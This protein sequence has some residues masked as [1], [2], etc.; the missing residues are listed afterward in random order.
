MPLACTLKM[1]KVVNVCYAYFT[2]IKIALVVFKVKKNNVPLS[3]GWEGM[4][5][6][7][8]PQLLVSTWAA[9]L[10]KGKSWDWVWHP[11]PGPPTQG[12]HMEFV[13]LSEAPVDHLLRQVLP[14]HQEHVDL[15]SVE[16]G[17]LIQPYTWAAPHPMVEAHRTGGGRENALCGNLGHR[18]G[19][20]F[21]GPR[22]RGMTSLKLTQIHL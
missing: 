14:L 16:V 12:T 20:K 11:L 22:A 13:D 15:G 18:K 10:R 19:N 5:G 7:W 21:R 2:K 8:V 9:P 6:L 3:V 17:H 4:G 1:G